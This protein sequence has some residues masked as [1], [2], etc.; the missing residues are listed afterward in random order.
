MMTTTNTKPA[1]KG[2]Q[3]EPNCDGVSWGAMGSESA[4]W[5]AE[6]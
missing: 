1:G 2:K 5:D 3:Q 6:G 4:T